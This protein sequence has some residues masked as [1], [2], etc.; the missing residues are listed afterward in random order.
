MADNLTIQVCNIVQ[1]V[2]AP[3]PEDRSGRL[4]FEV[5]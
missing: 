4:R 3:Q 1:V 2:T 5:K